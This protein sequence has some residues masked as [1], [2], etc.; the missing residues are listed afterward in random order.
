MGIESIGA[1]RG[2]GR[3]RYETVVGSIQR[4]VD[5]GGRKKKNAQTSGK[6]SIG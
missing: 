1:V 4:A 2:M 5:K 6:Q 3:A